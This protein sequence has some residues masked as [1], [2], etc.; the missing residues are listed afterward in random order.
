MKE[1]S[2]LTGIIFKNPGRYMQ[3]Q[4]VQMEKSI[5]MLKEI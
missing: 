1:F 5:G 2:Y 4:Q 3:L